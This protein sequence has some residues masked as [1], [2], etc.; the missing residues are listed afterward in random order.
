MKIGSLW[1]GGQTHISAT[2]EGQAPQRLIVAF[3][4]I[5][6]LTP[7]PGFTS[8]FAN[9]CSEMWEAD[10]LSCWARSWKTSQER[11]LGMRWRCP[12]HIGHTPVQIWMKLLCCFGPC[13][14]QLVN[15]ETFLLL[16]ARRLGLNCF[17]SFFLLSS[18]CIATVW[19]WDGRKSITDLLPFLKLLRLRHCS[20]FLYVAKNRTT[21]L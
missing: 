19:H 18:C 21:F 17:D 11:S 12:R 6:L 5:P 4:T 3:S 14:L 13:L 8:A 2:S 9:A 16:H 10:W 20:F 7:Q 15:A 1:R